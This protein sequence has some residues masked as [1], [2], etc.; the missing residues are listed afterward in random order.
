MT[1]DIYN[2][3]Y[4]EYST[5]IKA[6]FARHFITKHTNKIDNI[7]AN[8][9]NV[10]NESSF[11]SNNDIIDIN[12][13]TCSKCG[14]KLSSKTY[15]NKHLIKCNGISNPLECPICHKIYA[16]RF[17]KSVHIKKCKIVSNDLIEQSSEEITEVQESQLKIIS[18]NKEKIEFDISHLDKK[19]LMI[20]IKSGNLH[21][22]FLYFIEKLFE[23]KY[24]QL[25]KK[26]SLQYKY[27]N[28]HIGN[29]NWKVFLDKYIYPII[30]TNISD[31]ICNYLETSSTHLKDLDLYLNIMASNGY[32]ND[33]SLEYKKKY[34]DNIEQLK[35]LFNGFK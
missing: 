28:V 30:M 18:L 6:N 11:D 12:S 33:N 20:N 24:N 8:I 1:S 2:C 14:K 19:E 26:R 25:I 4:C 16:N 21:T 35:L 31:T 17:S 15:L 13:T 34:K 27:S 5:N 9:Q 22:S 23:N 32:S 29:N 10:T 3:M 7:I